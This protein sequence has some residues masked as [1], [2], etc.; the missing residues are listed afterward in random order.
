MHVSATD[1]TPCPLCYA[2]VMI[3]DGGSVLSLWLIVLLQE[4]GS[5]LHNHM[6]RFT[7]RERGGGVKRLREPETEASKRL[8]GNREAET[9]IFSCSSLFF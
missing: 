4:E 1:C 6:Y 7:Q 3:W 2:V 5:S 8:V 9:V